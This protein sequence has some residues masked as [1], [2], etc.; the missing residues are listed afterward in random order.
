[1]NRSSIFPSLNGNGTLS[2]LILL[3]NNEQ[4]QYSTF[5]S[6]YI[7]GVLFMLVVMGVLLY[8]NFFYEYTCNDVCAPIKQFVCFISKRCGKQKKTTNTGDQ[9]TS[10]V[11]GLE[12][13]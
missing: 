6:S 11:E 4:E 1:M 3:T 2:N 8:V 7:T 10:I 5:T 13:H 12:E 9:Y